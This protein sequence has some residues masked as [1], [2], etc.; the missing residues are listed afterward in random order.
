MGVPVALRS[1]MPFTLAA[2]KTAPS[3]LAL[4][5]MAPC[6]DA[7]LKLA[8]FSSAPVRS[9]NCARDKLKKCRLRAR[10]YEG[11]ERQL[12]ARG[13]LSILA[14][15]R[16]RGKTGHGIRRQRT[17]RLARSNVAPS[18][19]TERSTLAWRRASVK[20]VKLRSD[21]DRST[22][23]SSARRGDARKGACVRACE[24]CCVHLHE[25]TSEP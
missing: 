23:W 22:A 11:G 2:V 19:L 7:P 20:S 9:A 16:M 8:F 1:K 25:K 3:M 13:A 4:T 24:C 18:A 12:R 6:I 21:S 5:K 17:S 14:M 10:A 15:Q